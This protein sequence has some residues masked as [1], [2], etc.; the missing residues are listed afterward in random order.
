MNAM[1]AFSNF[2]RTACVSAG[3]ARPRLSTS[4]HRTAS[5]R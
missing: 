1:F 4:A 2:N 3:A 5:A